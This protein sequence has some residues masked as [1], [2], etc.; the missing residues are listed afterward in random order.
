[1]R[2]VLQFV[3]LLSSAAEHW[4]RKSGVVSSILTEGTYIL[5]H[6]TQSAPWIYQ[7]NSTLDR[8]QPCIPC[9]HCWNSTTFVFSFITIWLY[10]Q[11]W[12]SFKIMDKDSIIYV[13][14]LTCRHR[15]RL[16]YFIRHYVYANASRTVQYFYWRAEFMR[17]WSPKGTCIKLWTN[18]TAVYY[19]P[20][21]YI[22]SKIQNYESWR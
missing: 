21:R 10:A 5:S 12:G 15:H 3:S 11:F 4:S 13:K 19:K 16:K 17:I 7:V 18:C 2:K 1:M 22:I 6:F 8:R 14:L 9:V 20:I